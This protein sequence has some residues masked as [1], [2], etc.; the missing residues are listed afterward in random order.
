MLRQIYHMRWQATAIFDGCRRTERRRR[1]NC[2]N[3]SALKTTGLDWQPF[4]T[5]LETIGTVSWPTSMKVVAAVRWKVLKHQ[6]PSDHAASLWHPQRIDAVDSSAID[7]NWAA[8]KVGLTIVGIREMVGR[9]QGYFAGCRE[10]IDDLD[11]ARRNAFAEDA[12]EDRGVNGVNLDSPS[13]AP[14]RST[15]TRPWVPSDR[16][17]ALTVMGRGAGTPALLASLVV[18]VRRTGP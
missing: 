8:K 6:T 14:N 2:R 11:R 4:I 1:R 9:I 18:W 12:L 17:A 7:V 3:G 5:M 13:R 10:R 15:W 16:C